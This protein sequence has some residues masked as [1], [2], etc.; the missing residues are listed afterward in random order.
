MWNQVLRR[1]VHAEEEQQAERRR[2]Q[3]AQA[4]SSLS[5]ASNGAPTVSDV[6]VVVSQAATTGNES[7]VAVAPPVP[8][9]SAGPES[10][11]D[12][13]NEDEAQ[14]DEDY[15]QKHLLSRP[16]STWR[17]LEDTQQAHC[18]ALNASHTLLA[19]GER[20]GRVT[21]W[22][23]TSLRVIT[24]ELDPTLI[25]VESPPGEPVENQVDP[26]ARPSPPGGDGSVA[27]DDAS[28]EDDDD[29]VEDSASIEDEMDADDEILE[30]DA[31]P[32]AGDEKATRRHALLTLADLHVAR[33]ALKVVSQCAWSCDSRYLFAGC[34]ERA[35]RR[36]RLCVW[37]VHAATLEA[38]F[39]FDGPITTVSAHSYEP[40][41][42]LV[43]CWNALPVVVNLATG[44][45]TAL[46]SV[47]LD[48]PDVVPP[49]AQA[50]SRHPMLA[51]C[52]RYG[53]SSTRIYCATS[54]STLAVL[55][56]TTLQCLASLTLPVLIQFV[57]LCVNWHETALLVTS[58]KGIH[59][60]TMK[61]PRTREKSV[62]ETSSVDLQEVALHSTGAVRAPWAVCCFSGD[63]A[64]VVGTPVVRHRH[65]GE[66]G[67]FTWPRASL[68]TKTTAQHNVGVQ[69]GVLALAWDRVRH[70]VLAVSTSGA[71][72]VLEEQFATTWPGAMYPADFRLVT[73][74]EWH[75]Q[76]FE[77][78]AD[79]RKREKE[80][81]TDRARQAQV[82]VFGVTDP[83]DEVAEKMERPVG[84]TEG[85]PR[86][87][88]PAIPI[89]H[90]HRRATYQVDGVPYNEDKHF[91]LGQSV[92]EPLKGSVGTQDK[93]KGRRGQSSTK[94]RRRK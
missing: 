92:F 7:V 83:V 9:P 65:V 22:D 31:K 36:A 67:L 70:S 63:E 71:L 48:N 23:N 89:A 15:L 37:N 75:L 25:A 45:T 85:L 2:Q 42:V 11:V 19:V 35:T 74:N 47:P 38:A 3:L 54:K 44:T 49:T 14:D 21:I 27:Y 78:D 55:D 60:F 79:E 39:P 57:D 66:N 69:D 33:T 30:K 84:W 94:K 1:I 13:T 24:R 18:L 28:M 12:A 29:P 87:F 46:A 32:E 51:T 68:S 4:S 82:D 62:A 91:G 72:H 41:L 10:R 93:K 26:V 6:P 16:T 5:S 61:K 80:Q 77:R 86:V 8:T 34:E 88:L 20:D 50:T 59:E 58:S 52:A 17:C 73:D 90:Y 40:M 81:M 76:V 64:F 53:R 43:S 56:A